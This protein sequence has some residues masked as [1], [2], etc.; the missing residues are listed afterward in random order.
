MFREFSSIW[1][2]QDYIRSLVRH[3]LYVRS[4]SPGLATRR[5]NWTAV[6]NGAGLPLGAGG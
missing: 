1:E 5:P 6:R 2:I 4:G 3:D